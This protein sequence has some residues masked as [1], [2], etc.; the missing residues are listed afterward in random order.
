MK[1]S[2]AMTLKSV[3]EFTPKKFYEIKPWKHTNLILNQGFR[4]CFHNTPFSFKLANRNNKLKS[5][6]TLCW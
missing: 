1:L 3:S 6:I 2:L 5:Y 4:R